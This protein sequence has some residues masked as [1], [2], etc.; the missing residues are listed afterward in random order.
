MNRTTSE[1]LDDLATGVGLRR[2][3]EVEEFSNLIAWADANVVDDPEGAA[4][5]RD[6]Y[7]DTGIPIAGPSAP[8]V[9][10]FA[11]QEPCATL[12]RS[13]DSGRTYVGNVIEVGWRLPAIRDAVL[14]G[15]VP[16]W[17]A[18]KVAERTRSLSPEAAAFVDRHLGFALGGCTWTQIDR[19]VI[20]AID[21][22][23]PD[24]AEERRQDAADR[25]HCTID[26]Q[27]TTDGVVGQASVLDL[28]DAL[29]LEEAVARRAEELRLSGS[30]DSLDVRR[31]I[32]LGEI[33]RG[34]LSLDLPIADPETG[35]IKKTLKGRTLELRVHLSEAAITGST[36][37]TAVEPANVA[38]LENTQTPITVEQIR[39]W[40]AAEGTTVIVRPV[41]DLAGHHPIDSYE[42]PDRLRL[43]VEMRDPYCRAP[44]C[45]RR[46]EHCDLDHVVPHN[47]GGPTCPC[48]L[49]PLCRRHHRA[50]TFEFWVYEIL[51]PGLYLWTSKNGR[52]FIVG[53]QGTH[54]LE[55]PVPR[56]PAD[57][58]PP[59]ADPGF[60][61]H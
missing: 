9:S 36:P 14:A 57:D 5:I 3:V 31:S 8:L 32:A 47:K 24:A 34:D 49:V 25:R 2:R 35:E 48:N 15:K 40:A 16:V 53:P 51:E 29:A 1:L 42:I 43:I 23:D 4:T 26:L 38:R 20:E 22:F 21:R 52:R 19:V 6:S 55:P 13:L 10:E 30:T 39:A 37:N 33:A 44:H 46:A 12:G 50:K 17:K 45:T 60:P 56:Y 28:A 18:L 27:E 61:E 59:W 54:A 11:L 58:E 7:V 41:I